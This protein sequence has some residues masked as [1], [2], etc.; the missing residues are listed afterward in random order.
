LKAQCRNTTIYAA[1]KSKHCTMEIAG[2]A[3]CRAATNGARKTLPML[4]I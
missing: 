1:C 4:E 3:M 2:V